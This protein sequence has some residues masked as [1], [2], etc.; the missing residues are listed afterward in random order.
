MRTTLSIERIDRC[1]TICMIIL[2]TGQPGAGKSTVIE[3]FIAL[4]KEP[5][6]WVVTTGIPRPQFGERGGFIAANSNGEKRVISHKTDIQSNI[7]I[8]ENHVDLTAVGAM[9]ANALDKAAGSG[10][11]TI[12][13]EVGPIQLLSPAFTASLEHVFRGTGNMVATIHYND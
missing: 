9:F 13:D 8:G 6:D 11:L 10:A 7:V 12:I 5:A 3:K 2:L 1:Y 4:N